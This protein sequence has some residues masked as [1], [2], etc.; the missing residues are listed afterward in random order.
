[1]HIQATQDNR[2]TAYRVK[3]FASDHLQLQLHHHQQRLTP[4][5]ISDVTGH[6]AS[7]CFDKENIPDLNRGDEVAVRIISPDLDGEVK[8]SA[9]VAFTGDNS[10]GRLYG[11]CFDTNIDLLNQGN[12]DLLRL[13]NRRAAYRGVEPESPNEL[14]AI[15]QTTPVVLIKTDESRKVTVRNISTTGVCL[16]IDETLA[17]SLQGTR[18]ISLSLQIPGSAVAREYCARIRNRIQTEDGIFYGCYFVWRDMDDALEAIEEITNYT[19]DRLARDQEHD[20]VKH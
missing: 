15:V 2:R 11:L 7:I 4:D 18:R 3:P 8:L 10:Q 16:R 9:H 20:T 13:F 17:N 14:Q 6:G 5:L 1:M 12:R 19:L